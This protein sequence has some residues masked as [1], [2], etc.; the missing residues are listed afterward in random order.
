M[1]DAAGKSHFEGTKVLV[2]KS[3]IAI[4]NTFDIAGGK[5]IRKLEVGEVLDILEEPAPDES[6]S[7]LR[8]KA[9]SQKD[10]KEGWVTMKGNQGTAYV[11]ETTKHYKCLRSVDLEERFQA[12]GPVV[13]P[14][15]EGETFEVLEGPKTDT[16][17]GANRARG[18]N[19]GDGAEGW[20]TLT[21]KNMQV[22]SPNY[23]CRAPVDLC[24]DIE[25]SKVQRKLE[26]GERLEALEPPVFCNDVVTIRLRAESDGAVGFATSKS[27]SA[28]F[29]DP[30]RLA[31]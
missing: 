19:L 17:Q 3:S 1:R 24:E 6:R 28:V 12:G 31:R 5:A 9:R 7:L 2:C 23:K 14:L 18:R 25:C 11:E 13:R 30:V 20:F 22:W 26:A 8:V 10:D 27:Q 21:K 15:E 16:K 29:L 4:T